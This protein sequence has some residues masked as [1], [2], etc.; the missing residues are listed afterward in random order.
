MVL[1][2][3]AATFFPSA[4]KDTAHGRGQRESADN[5][6]SR[7]GAR[8]CCHGGVP[9]G[10]ADCRIDE[11]PGQPSGKRSQ[12]VPRPREPDD[13]RRDVLSGLRVLL[14]SSC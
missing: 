7:G 4:G 2:F 5:G 1:G 13:P 6:D 12:V 9:H 3:A 14:G 8:R 11:R 10:K